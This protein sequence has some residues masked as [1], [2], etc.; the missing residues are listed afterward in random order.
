MG[1]FEKIEEKLLTDQTISTKDYEHALKVRNASEMKTIKDYHDFYWECD[2]LL[3][4][5][6]FEK[7]RTISLKSQS[8]LSSN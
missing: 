8:T 7:F 3:L 1:D 5:D 6:V 2:V 4:T